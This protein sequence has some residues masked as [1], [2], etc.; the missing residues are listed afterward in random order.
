MNQQFWVVGGEYHCLEFRQINGTPCALGP[1]ENYEA[2]EKVWRKHTEASR[3]SAATRYTILATATNP[4][5]EL[6]AA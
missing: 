3:S 6:R 1:F 5:R 4:R 2:A